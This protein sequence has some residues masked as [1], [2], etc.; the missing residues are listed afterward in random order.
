MIHNT[1]VAKIKAG[2]CVGS[3]Q[4]I[5]QG[6]VVYSGIQAFDPDNGRGGTVSYSMMVSTSTTGYNVQKTTEGYIYI[7]ACVHNIYFLY[8]RV[9]AKLA[10][11]CT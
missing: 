8:M 5:P 4:S 10:H 11:V 9:R 1:S 7:S 2:E 6:T 3:L